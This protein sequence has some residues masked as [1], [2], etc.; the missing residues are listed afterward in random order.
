MESMI[1]LAL[2]TLVNRHDALRATISSCHEDYSVEKAA[3][4]R[5]SSSMK[6]GYLQVDHKLNRLT[7]IDKIL[8]IKPPISCRC[9]T[10]EQMLQSNPPMCITCAL[11]EE[12]SKAFDM[13][14]QLF[15]CSIFSPS[16]QE[17][18]ICLVFH[19][20]ISD[21]M[22]LFVITSELLA[23]LR[24]GSDDKRVT[25]P[26]EHVDFVP[27]S[28][29][30]TSKRAIDKWVSLLASAES[31]LDMWSRQHGRHISDGK[32]PH[33]AS[34]VFLELSAKSIRAISYLSLAY[35]V[36]PAV[37]IAVA[38][39]LALSYVTGERDVVIGMVSANRTRSTASAVG[40]FANTLPLR[41]N[42]NTQSA[43]NLQ[44]L[45][46]DVRKNWSMILAGCVDL[47]D[48]IP[49][50]PCLQYK[51]SGRESTVRASP[52]QVLFSFYDV[53]QD[54]KFSNEFIVDGV[55]VECKVDVPKPGHTHADLWMEANPNQLND[56]GNQ[57]FHWE[58]RTSILTHSIVE[59]LHTILC[60]YLETAADAKSSGSDCIHPLDL[61]IDVSD[62][63]L[64]VVD[65]SK[66]FE[67]NRE[68]KDISSL[69]YIQRFQQKVFECPHS[70][71][72]KLTNNSVYTYHDVHSM[73]SV[74]ALY[75]T[76]MLKVKPGDRVALLLPRDVNLYL[77]L[78]AVHKCGAAY[79]PI[80]SDAALPENENRLIQTLKVAGAKVLL[81]VKSVWSGRQ[82]RIGCVALLDDVISNMEKYK[83]LNLSSADL[84]ILAS[85]E[86][87]YSPDLLVYILFTSGT[88]GEP[89]AVGITNANLN[90]T[91]NNFLHLLSP[92]ETRLTLAAT[93][94]NFDSHV[95]D[96]LAPLLNGSCLVV[97][98]S[99]LDLSYDGG[100]PFLSDD[101]VRNS[102]FNDSGI[103]TSAMTSS[104]FDGITFAFATPSTASVVSYPHSMEAIMIGGEVFTRACY[105]N[106][107]HIPR[108]LN[109][110][111]PTECSVFMTAIEVPKL[112]PTHDHIDTKE[113]SR[114]GWPLPDV[115]VMIMND[116]K[117]IVP[118]G[119]IGELHIAGPIV[120][121]S[122]YLN[123]AEKNTQCF[124]VSPLNP[125]ERVYATGD[126]MYMLPNRMLQFVGRKD[127]Q[128]KLRGMRLHLQKV[129]DTLSS[130]PEVRYA[131]SLV[132]N[133]ATSSATLVSFVTP[134]NVDKSS[135]LEHARHHLP[136]YMVPSVVVTEDEMID[137]KLSKEYIQQ[138]A[139]IALE[140]GGAASSVSGKGDRSI[141]APDQ[142]KLASEMSVIFGR[143]LNVKDYPVEGDFFAF[144]GHSLLC[145]QLVK[146][147]NRE[148]NV[149][150]S[151]T[152]VMQNSTP[153]DLA[154]A[155]LDSKVEKNL[156]DLCGPQVLPQP[157]IRNVKSTFVINGECLHESTNVFDYLE[158]V[159]EV[160]LSRDI[161]KYFDQ[162]QKTGVEEATSV[163]N[164]LAEETG[165]YIPPASLIHYSSMDIL[166]VHLK[167][168]T[169]L[170]FTSQPHKVVAVLTPP[171]SA[172][173]KLIFFIH[174]GVIGWSLSYVKLAKK[175][176]GHGV[177]VQRTLEA[178]DSTFEEMVAFYLEQVQSV[179]SRG[180]Y[181][182]VGVCYGA[183]VVYEMTR[184][185]VEKGEKVELSVLINN[186]PVNEKRPAIF[187]REG[188]P[189][190]N[191]MAHP[192]HF[193]ETTLK[194]ARDNVDF[195]EL[196]N[197]AA[198]DLDA[199]TRSLVQAYPWLPFSASEL[200]EAYL[201]FIKTLR[202]AWFGY[203]PKPIK[204]VELVKRVLLIRNK[205]H[206]FFDS[207]DF[208]LLKLIN[209][210]DALKV[211]AS[212]TKLGLLNEEQTVE[213]ISDVIRQN[214]A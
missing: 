92:Q 112:P 76:K 21:G 45:M 43:S 163:S 168:K 94:I 59:C 161:Q 123:A 130:H 178:P 99:A 148:M 66:C 181:K 211:I 6:S 176:G 84:G 205:E 146:E 4:S 93:G 22:S 13:S 147:M 213:F 75:L 155:M 57:T 96:S 170:S 2:Y 138:R 186:S 135:L 68:A 49:L 82:T 191:T 50:V 160:P 24:D 116:A 69:C 196:Y 29:R 104:H 8:K 42:L 189:L 110:Y 209:N 132:I 166:Q 31:C 56:S 129:T 141:A 30:V 212:S 63:S 25:Q 200:A 201:Q 153:V 74:V 39:S 23:L 34:E 179:Q 185:L 100:T 79:V 142:L 145:F 95:L 73:T 173:D 119:R 171:S 154:R 51:S 101:L 64:S 184:Q 36:S 199:L 169:V 16:S 150:L 124:L 55:E 44:S 207:N 122:G 151:L 131:K 58:Y 65:G 136:P 17:A 193:F 156:K 139:L 108:V 114:I 48:L 33:A 120:S 77:I 60:R 67:K 152:H 165:F 198:V 106:T 103:C 190:P 35:R 81:T 180:P 91:F 89:K 204:R 88:T 7:E 1:Q 70:P 47:L 54:G 127:D 52:L 19:H 126:L 61:S 80:T 18:V 41:I 172:Y 175:I 167:L 210:A 149:R 5:P 157:S 109:I 140:E 10:N 144:G 27:T 113:I 177:A 62:L 162:L 128:V 28:S 197:V 194:V 187:N 20:L 107:K 203:T 134:K 38:Y 111:G 11:R 78:L 72:F 137:Y 37:V 46:K 143:V 195:K 15:R 206:V 125:K 85:L 192:L 90:V 118:I 9:D 158:P 26:E 86:E 14:R 214:L 102:D 202:P 121:S 83:K 71:A 105:F 12:I 87:A 97:A 174:S 115:K 32:D 40:Y 208:G 159:P 53:G 3:A 182:L 98:K 133:P 164:L 117:N 183:Y 188:Q